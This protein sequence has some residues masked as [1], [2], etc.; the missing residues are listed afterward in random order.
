MSCEKAKFETW[1]RPGVAG[2]GQIGE[3]RQGLELT[4]P[5][6]H[7]FIACSVMENGILS[8]QPQFQIFSFTWLVHD[9]QNILNFVFWISPGLILLYKTVGSYPSDQSNTSE[10]K[11]HSSLRTDFEHRRSWFTWGLCR[12][13]LAWTSVRKRSWQSLTS[14]KLVEFS[15]LAVKAVILVSRTSAMR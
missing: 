4:R 3:R 15:N 6:S 5:P 13:M 10:P 7:F 8:Q 1:E 11:Q 12:N 14:S 2:G 9:W